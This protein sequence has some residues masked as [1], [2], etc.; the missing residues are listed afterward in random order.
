MKEFSV[1]ICHTIKIRTYFFYSIGASWEGLGCGP[2][3]ACIVILE[4]HYTCSWW[5]FDVGNNS[6]INIPISIDQVLD[7]TDAHQHRCIAGATVADCTT[8]TAQMRINLA[9]GV[10]TCSRTISMHASHQ[11]STS[12]T[13]Q[14][15]MSQVVSWEGHLEDQV[16][17]DESKFCFCVSNGY[18]NVW[19]NLWEQHLATYIY[20]WYTGLNYSIMVKSA[21]I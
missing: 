16:F 7:S 20:P 8:S 17:C 12:A 14:L 13:T 19:C 3:R 2:W 6:R 21:I 4:N 9:L 18:M 5:C 1:N 11:I 10:F 15:C